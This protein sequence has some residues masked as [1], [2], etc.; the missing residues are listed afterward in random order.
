MLEGRW[1]AVGCFARAKHLL[2]P[3][4][5]ILALPARRG[6]MKKE[7]GKKKRAQHANQNIQAG[8]LP[9]GHCLLSL[10][11]LCKAKP[12]FVNRRDLTIDFPTLSILT[13]PLRLSLL[14]PSS[15]VLLVG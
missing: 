7:K 10:P 14:P 12:G 15:V 4:T 5:S 2:H 1:A 11:Q 13:I 9:S 6:E 8:T 3:A